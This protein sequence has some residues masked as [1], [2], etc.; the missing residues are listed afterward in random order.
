MITLAVS[1]FI[2]ILG[3]VFYGRFVE[4]MFAPDRRKTPAI[5]MKDDVDYIP[6]PTWKAT[7]IQLLNIAGTGPIFGALM[8][9]CFGPV[10]F[11]WIVLGSILGGAVHDY[12]SG[13][14][15]ERHQGRSIAELSGVYLGPVGLYAMRVFSVLLLILTGAVFIST[16]AMLLAKIAPALSYKYWVIEILFYYTLATLLPIDKIIGW[17]YPIFGAAL[18]VMAALVLGALVF[19][20]GGYAIPELTLANLHPNDVPVWP[21]MF[22]TVACGAISG[23]HS[24]QSPLMAKCMTSEF[25][26]RKIFYGAMII[27]AAIALIW[28]A[29]GMAFYEDV[30]GVEALTAALAGRG[31]SG[32]VFSI[33]NGLLGQVGAVL[34][35]IGVV[36]CPITSGDT[37]FRVVRMIVAEWLKID[38]ESF[39]SRLLVTVPLMLVGAGLT[40]V[41]FNAL[42]RYFSWANQTLAMVALWVATAYLIKREKY[43]FSSLITAIPAAFMTAVTTTYIMMAPEGFKLSSGISYTAGAVFALVLFAIYARSA[44]AKAQA[45]ERENDLNDYQHSY[46]FYE[47][48]LLSAQAPLPQNTRLPGNTRLPQNTQLPRDTRLPSDSR[49][50]RNSRL[51]RQAAK[52]TLAAKTESA[53]TFGGK[54]FAVVTVLVVALFSFKFGEKAEQRTWDIAKQI[55]QKGCLACHATAERINGPSFKEIA[56]KYSN[57][58]IMRLTKKIIAGSIGVWGNEMCPSHGNVTQAEA[59]KMAV[60]MLSQKDQQEQS[61]LLP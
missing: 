51:P 11:L 55:E 57:D 22:I 45:T 8:G 47:S 25:A 59:R 12:M 58:H 19:G 31:P 53:I 42:W 41:D 18:A 7:M 16:P 48:G 33:S 2:L 24:T 6:M 34:A 5:T 13:M 50:P 14:I 32:V 37:S 4:H 26:G 20:S 35:I 44:L 3:Y 43:R 1:M 49:P 23:F 10:V 9:A 40:Q 29:A 52:R 39:T 30:G 46:E 54:A 15:S 61:Q 17:F 56:N 27:E 60:W 21:F 28:A 38:Q 36:V